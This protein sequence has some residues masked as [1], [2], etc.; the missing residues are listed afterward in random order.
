MNEQCSRWQERTPP[1]DILVTEEARDVREAE[2]RCTTLLSST[3][4]IL[5]L[6]SVAQPPNSRVGRES[7]NLLAL[8]AG[9]CWKDVA[10]ESKH[11]YPFSLFSVWFTSLAFLKIQGK[12]KEYIELL[13]SRVDSLNKIR[14]TCSLF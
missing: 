11:P 13:T 2:G 6:L 10:S 5:L 7:K 1:A 4:P 3:F 9:A 8:G 14:E 12:G